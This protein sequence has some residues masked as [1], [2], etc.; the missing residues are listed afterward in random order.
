MNDDGTLEYPYI[1]SGM[2]TQNSFYSYPRQNQ[3]ASLIYEPTY[4]QVTSS[5]R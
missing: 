4:A 5:L 3:G 1:R 2:S